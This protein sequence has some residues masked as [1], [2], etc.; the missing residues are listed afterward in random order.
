MRETIDVIDSSRMNSGR[1]VR[2]TAGQHACF[3]RI[4]PGGQ[5]F[6]RSST[7][8]N[9]VNTAPDS[10]DCWNRTPEGVPYEV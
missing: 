9:E 4:D 7:G 10:A 2:S 1:Y 5:L 6:A 3:Y 8:S